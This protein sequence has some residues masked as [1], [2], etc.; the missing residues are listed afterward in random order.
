VVKV[1]AE[2][3]PKY[4]GARVIFTKEVDDNVIKDL[5]LFKNEFED[6][7]D[8]LYKKLEERYNNIDEQ[9]NNV[10]DLLVKIDQEDPDWFFEVITD[11]ISDKY[12][13]YDYNL[14]DTFIRD[15]ENRKEKLKNFVSMIKEIIDEI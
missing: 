9:V 14:V 11:Y 13:D 6:L 3:I 4:I 8:V 2:D 5:L 10:Y 12:D 15:K 7:S 1:D